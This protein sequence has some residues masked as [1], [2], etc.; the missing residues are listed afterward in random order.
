MQRETQREYAHRREAERAI[1][2]R[3]EKRAQ[4]K[5]WKTLAMREGY[6]AIEAARDA[7]IA[8]GRDPGPQWVSNTYHKW[9]DSK[10]FWDTYKSIKYR[11]A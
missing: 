2:A 1:L 9:K 5:K 7:R 11:R 4:E 3:N 10:D 6:R 8:M